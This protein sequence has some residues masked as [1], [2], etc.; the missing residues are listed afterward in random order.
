MT[1]NKVI[2]LAQPGTLRDSLTEILRNGARALLTQA[3]EAEA[4]FRNFYITERDW[5]NLKQGL[6]AF[7]TEQ[8]G[9]EADREALDPHSAEARRQEVT[10]LVQHDQQAEAHDGDDNRNHRGSLPAGE[11]SRHDGFRNRRPL[12]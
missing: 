3:V 6:A 5:G 12:G 8:R 10:A 2:K 11:G 7:E 4:W 9:S 1:D